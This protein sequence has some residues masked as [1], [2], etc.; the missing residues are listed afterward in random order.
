MAI[1]QEWWKDK[2]AE[3]IYTNLK[4]K[5][6]T[7]P[8]YYGKSSHLWLRRHLVDWL[9]VI[10]GELGIC[11]TAHHLAIYLLDYFMDNMQIEKYY[12]H[13]MALCCLLVAGEGGGVT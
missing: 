11:S 1:E 10:V 3:D 7:L 9:S 6:L 12:L 8:T 2:L 5:E 4:L 13:L